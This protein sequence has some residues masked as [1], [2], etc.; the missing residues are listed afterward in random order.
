MESSGTLSSPTSISPQKLFTCHLAALN[1]RLDGVLSVNGQLNKEYEWNTSKRCVCK[2]W[3]L[4]AVSQ[5]QQLRAI[6]KEEKQGWI[7]QSCPTE[8]KQICAILLYYCRL[9]SLFSFSCQSLLWLNNNQCNNLAAW[10]WLVWLNA[11]HK[12]E[13]IKLL[14]LSHLKWFIFWAN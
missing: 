4:H 5:Q 6:Y 14:V 9:N 12:V 2:V 1:R 11:L 10:F 3:F 8:L 7:L 13:P